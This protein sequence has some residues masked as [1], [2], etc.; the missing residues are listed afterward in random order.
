MMSLPHSKRRPLTINAV[1]RENANVA[2][3]G[4][5]SKQPNSYSMRN[6]KEKSIDI[7]LY[8]AKELVENGFSDYYSLVETFNDQPTLK[9]YNSSENLGNPA[10]R[11]TNYYTRVLTVGES[12]D[13]EQVKSKNSY[14]NENSYWM[15]YIK[16]DYTIHTLDLT[17]KVDFIKKL[18]PSGMVDGFGYL[19]I[20]YDPLN[21]VLGGDAKLVIDFR[22]WEKS[23]SSEIYYA[24][25]GKTGLN[26]SIMVEF[27][28]STLNLEKLH[29]LIKNKREY[30][31]ES[32]AIENKQD[33][34]IYESPLPPSELDLFETGGELDEDPLTDEGRRAMFASKP[35]TGMS[36]LKGLL[37]VQNDPTTP[38]ERPKFNLTMGGKPERIVLNSVVLND[39]N[40]QLLQRIIVNFLFLSERYESLDKPL[41]NASQFTFNVSCWSKTMMLYKS[42]PNATFMVSEPTYSDLHVLGIPKDMVNTERLS[43]KQNWMFTSTSNESSFKFS[44]AEIAMMSNFYLT[45][46]DGKN[47]SDD[48]K[49]TSWSLQSPN[50]PF[51]FGQTFFYV[52]DLTPIPVQMGSDEYAFPSGTE[53][54]I[55]L[56]SD[57]EMDQVNGKSHKSMIIFKSYEDNPHEYTLKHAIIFVD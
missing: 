21:K 41:P 8:S 25:L 15:A 55:V 9:I 35:R 53:S 19:K 3:I 42:S 20:E 57:W 10:I 16:S 50:V 6:K 49:S 17:D 47:P 23:P 43:K 54:L 22:S 38:I 14:M 56:T 39:N 51:M 7:T 5:K 29:M 46:Q 13:D 2:L 27:D 48:D 34:M 18:T 28:P 4:A 11:L 32:I 37:Y 45:F 33:S 52:K 40:W 30:T 12:G 36:E 31:K 24:P 44:T 1:H 26:F